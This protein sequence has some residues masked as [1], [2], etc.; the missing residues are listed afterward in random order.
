L[1]SVRAKISKIL[2]INAV[3]M[4]RGY[5][6]HWGTDYSNELNRRASN[7]YHFRA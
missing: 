3:V 7:D 4:A 1:Q 5:I 2:G 6:S